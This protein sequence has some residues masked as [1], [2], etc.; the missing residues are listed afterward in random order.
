MLSFTYVSGHVCLP[1][2][3]GVQIGVDACRVLVFSSLV[4]TLPYHAQSLHMQ[5]SMPL[6]PL[7]WIS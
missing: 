3:F 6:R 5:S 7:H 1:S 4:N 2:L